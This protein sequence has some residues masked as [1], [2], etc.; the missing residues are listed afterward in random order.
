MVTDSVALILLSAFVCCLTIAAASLDWDNSIYCTFKNRELLLSYP[1]NPT[2]EALRLRGQRVV[3]KMDTLSNWY[4]PA[5]KYVEIVR[6]DHPTRPTLGIALGFEFDERNGE[7]PYTP[8]RAVLQLKDFGWGGVEFSYRD[9]LNYTG[10]SNEVSDD[11]QIEI[12]AYRNDTIYGHF[13][14]LLLSGAGPMGSIEKGKFAVKVYRI[15]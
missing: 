11:L 15:E 5:K 1:M 2:P 10:I 6:Q 3:A 12:E 4:D 9:T 13:S 7:Y 8:S 14:G